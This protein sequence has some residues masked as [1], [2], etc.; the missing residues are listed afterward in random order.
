VGNILDVIIRNKD[1][2]AQIVKIPFIK[3]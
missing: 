1:I 2:K 3:K